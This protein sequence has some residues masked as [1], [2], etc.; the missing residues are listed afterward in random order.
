MPSGYIPIVGQWSLTG[1]TRFR[2]SWL[3]GRPVIQIEE[4]RPTGHVKGPGGPN[5]N[6]SAFRWRDADLTDLLALDISS[7]IKREEPRP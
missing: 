2:P 1:A 3:F 4:R 5:W 6:G 7:T